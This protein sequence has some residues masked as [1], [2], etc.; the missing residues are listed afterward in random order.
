MMNLI[1]QLTYKASENYWQTKIQILTP[2]DIPI[3]NWQNKIVEK[4]IRIKSEI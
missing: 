1:I 3:E 4:V 2:D